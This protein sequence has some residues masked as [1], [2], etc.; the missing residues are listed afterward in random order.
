MTLK[1]YYVIAVSLK[2]FLQTPLI[3]ISSAGWCTELSHQCM[4]TLPKHSLS[5]KT[6]CRHNLS[7]S[8]LEHQTE[9]NRWSQLKTLSCLLI[10]VHTE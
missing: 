5:R 2:L 4:D 1:N 10:P 7:W 8:H 3:T 9:V 6:K